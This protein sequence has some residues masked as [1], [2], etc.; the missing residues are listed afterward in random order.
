[1]K[2]G[3]PTR[4]TIERD[5]WLKT[6]DVGH[7]SER[8]FLVLMDRRADL[9]HLPGGPVPPAIVERALAGSPLI[10]DVVVIGRGRKVTV[11]LVVPDFHEL[12]RRVYKHQP[13]LAK[14]ATRRTLLANVASR[15]TA[16]ME[17]MTRY[18][19]AKLPD[20]ARPRKVRL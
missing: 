15:I 13:D 1:G 12:A 6:G 5:G 9:I 8:G 14:K 16:E 7:V 4:A 18:M 11:A 3:P 20:F 2:D 10:H 19:Q 17:V